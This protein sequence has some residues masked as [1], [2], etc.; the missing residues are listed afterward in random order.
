MKT[1]SFFLIAILVV[2]AG[3]VAVSRVLAFETSLFAGPEY[4][5]VTLQGLHKGREFLGASVGGAVSSSE[6]TGLH[7]EASG[8]FLKDMASRE[9]SFNYGTFLWPRVGYRIKLNDSWS[10]TPMAGVYLG[11]INRNSNR[12]YYGW[13]N[14]ELAFISTGGDLKYN[15]GKG[16]GFHI[17]VNAISPIYW[18]SESRTHPNNLSN[19]WQ[20]FIEQAHIWAK[21]GISQGPW[22]ADLGYEKISTNE[23]E[24]NLNRFYLRLTYAF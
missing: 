3:L 13:Q 18:Q 4:L 19:F 2:F 11:Y 17:D 22:R 15:L 6:G 5:N 23:Q 16:W 1:G 8:E 24:W 14:M 10:L 20:G 12:H 7:W 21:T 9:Y